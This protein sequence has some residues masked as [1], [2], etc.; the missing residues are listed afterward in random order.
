MRRELDESTGLSD[1]FVADKHP[2]GT[3]ADGSHII[4]VSQGGTSPLEARAELFAEGILGDHSSGGRRPGKDETE[5]RTANLLVQHLNRAGEYWDAPEQP[6]GPEEGVDCIARDRRDSSVVL[7]IQ[8]TTPETEAW[9]VLA[10]GAQFSRPRKSLNAAV[11]ALR[12]A[13]ERKRTRAAKNVVLALDAVDNP[14]HAL[15]PVIQE[16]TSNDQNL[17]MALGM[18]T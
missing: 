10:S 6:T 11:E 5:L 12:L 8:V 3:G 2:A 17:W 18:V 7:K 1:G 15:R 16:F 9:K 14:R 13:I 4:H